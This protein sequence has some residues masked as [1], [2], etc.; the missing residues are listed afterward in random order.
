M[1]QIG[2]IDTTHDIYLRRRSKERQ[3]KDHVSQSGKMVGNP[4]GTLEEKCAW[5]REKQ[6]R[7]REATKVVRRKA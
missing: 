2:K 6:K 1:S 5:L 3:R 4:N 7:L